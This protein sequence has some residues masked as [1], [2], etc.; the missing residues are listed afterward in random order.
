MVKTIVNFV[1]PFVTVEE[2]KYEV[3]LDGKIAKITIS[4]QQNPESFEKVTKLKFQDRGDVKLNILPDPHG[5]VNY[6]NVTIEIPSYYDPNKG[7]PIVIDDSITNPLKQDCISYINRL[8]EVVRFSTSKYWIPRINE[9]DILTF[10]YTTTDDSGKTRSGLYSDFGRGRT[11]PLVIRQQVT[12]QEQISD[13]LRNEGKI[14]LDQNLFLD[15]INYF[16][17]GS[18]NEAV[19]IVNVA[20]EVLVQKHLFERFKNKGFQDDDANKKV[21]KIFSKE[22]KNGKKG[23]HKILTVDFEEI[24]KKSLENSLD[25]WIKF[26]KMRSTR[27]NAIHPKTKKIPPEEAKNTIETGFQI[28]NWILYQSD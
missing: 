22:K 2:G 21:D 11:F 18:F 28:A 1:L 14:P 5:I 26:N 20:L 15:S 27:K 4:F 13:F 9:Q 7:K 25:L 19:I 3:S 10:E 23:L 8:V 6:T 24:G 16:V 17:I 12:V